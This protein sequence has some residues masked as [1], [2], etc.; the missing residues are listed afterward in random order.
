MMTFKER[1]QRAFPVWRQMLKKSTPFIMQKAVAGGAAGAIAV[2]GIKKGDQ[3]IG[4]MHDTSGA[5]IADLTSE[6]VANCDP[7]QLIKV[8]GYIDNTG[9]TATTSDILIVTWLAWAE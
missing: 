5:V 8:D 9:G 2:T 7:G 6:F 1:L 3:L 4:V